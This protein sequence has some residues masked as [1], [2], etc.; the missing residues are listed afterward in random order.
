[1]VGKIRNLSKKMCDE[2]LVEMLCVMMKNRGV[3][4]RKRKL[5]RKKNVVKFCQFQK[6]D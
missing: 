2:K 4:V 3:F 6:S 1:M 5:H